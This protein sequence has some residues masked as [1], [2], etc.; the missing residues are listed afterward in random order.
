LFTGRVLRAE[1]WK[2]EKVAEEA[3]DCSIAMRQSQQRKQSLQM[4]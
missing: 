3:G 1:A 4:K 2:C